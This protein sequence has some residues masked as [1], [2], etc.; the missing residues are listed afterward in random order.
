[1]LG[2]GHTS[3]NLIPSPTLV[4]LDNEAMKRRRAKLHKLKAVKRAEAA[5]V[6]MHGDII[7]PLSG[8]LQSGIEDEP[9]FDDEEGEINDEPVDHRLH[10]HGEV[11]GDPFLN[12]PIDKF[13]RSENDFEPILPNNFND[14]DM[15]VGDILPFIQNDD[16]ISF[17]SKVHN[18]YAPEQSSQASIA[19]PEPEP[20][21][22]PRLNPTPVKPKAPEPRMK[23]ESEVKGKPQTMA[24]ALLNGKKKS[25]P[26]HQKARAHASPVPKPRKTDRS[27][28]LQA[29]DYEINP[30]SRRQTGFATPKPKSTVFSIRRCLDN[31]KTAVLRNSP[32][33]PAIVHLKSRHKNSVP[34]LNTTQSMIKRNDSPRVPSIPKTTRALPQKESKPQTINTKVSRNT[35]KNGK[36]SL[37]GASPI[38]IHD[39]STSR[40]S[41]TTSQSAKPL[42]TA[43]VKN[44]KVFSQLFIDDGVATSAKCTKP[45]ILVHQHEERCDSYVGG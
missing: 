4:D 27:L 21:S 10:H 33:R 24:I 13:Q 19:L 42:H 6:G 28:N 31:I 39:I 43:S 12:S 14:R 35:S 44:L 17:D 30:D 29:G 26:P 18:I 25:I 37:P 36:T 1:V 8:N 2:H 23:K 41:L 22:I 16:K 9:D 38:I 40:P 45:S 34:S 5:V 11:K 20:L 32:G 3:E 15:P 7:P